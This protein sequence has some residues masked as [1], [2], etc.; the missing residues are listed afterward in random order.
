MDF[1]PDT[2]IRVL[3][4]VVIAVV[5]IW[6]VGQFVPLL[7]LPGIVVTLLNLIIGVSA[8][9]AIVRELGLLK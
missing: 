3:V 2:I 9:I 5:L 6:V 7:G 1:T 4:I 8:L